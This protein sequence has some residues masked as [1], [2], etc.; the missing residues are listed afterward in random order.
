MLEADAY[1]HALHRAVH[2]QRLSSCILDDKM[3]ALLQRDREVSDPE[4]YTM[5]LNMVGTNIEY[6]QNAGHIPDEHRHDG[7]DYN[8]PRILYEIAADE[9]PL[10]N[11]VQ[12]PR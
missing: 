7:Q 5:L 2:D 11:L 1:P 9:F 3:D 4:K 12:Y 10:G 6:E 8:S